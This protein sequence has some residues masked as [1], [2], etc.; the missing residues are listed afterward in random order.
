MIDHFWY[1]SGVETDAGHT[2]GHCFHHHIRQILFERRD[3]EEVYG[4]VYIHQLM[5]IL[6]IRKRIDAE[7]NQVLQLLRL[8]AENNHAQ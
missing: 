8:V 5:L 6:N 2:A 4:I 7:R 3:G 1:A